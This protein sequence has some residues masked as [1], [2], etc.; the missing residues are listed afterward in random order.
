MDL[1]H[2]FFHCKNVCV[3]W[4]YRLQFRH[5]TL[6]SAER[7]LCVSARET[8]HQVLVTCRSSLRRWGQ[9]SNNNRR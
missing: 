4:L 3:V 5:C 9:Y 7:K 1:T 2:V 6:S 8:R